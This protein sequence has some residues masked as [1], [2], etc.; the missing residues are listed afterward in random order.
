MTD[1]QVTAVQAAFTMFEAS[2]GSKWAGGKP[3][4]WAL[5]MEEATA[6][7]IIGAAKDWCRSQEW[8]PSPKDLLDRIPRFCRCGK[9]WPCQ[10]RALD[11]ARKAVE[12][13]SLDA[14]QQIPQRVTRTDMLPERPALP[15]HE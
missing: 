12:R 6:T 8:P 10:M 15:A 7:E 3:S 11:R 1:D 14:A 13:G 5:L 4:V 9:C 2:Y